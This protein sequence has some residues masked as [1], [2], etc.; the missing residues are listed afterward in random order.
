MMGRVAGTVSHCAGSEAPAIYI[1]GTS[2]CADMYPDQPG[3]P[4]EL[5][6]ARRRIGEEVTKW[7]C[8]HY[9]C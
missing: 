4:E 3:D 6:L 9:E 2:H 8:Q 7:V 5:T 1:T